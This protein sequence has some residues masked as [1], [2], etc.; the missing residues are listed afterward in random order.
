MEEMP[1]GWALASVVT[2]QHQQPSCDSHEVSRL[3]PL[4]QR[5][6]LGKDAHTLIYRGRRCCWQGS[7]QAKSEDDSACAWCK[8]FES[9]VHGL[10]VAMQG[11][12]EIT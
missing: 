7:R 5:Y 11:N 2:M 4:D 8:Q 1:S 12:I 9:P 10:S 3:L 6:D